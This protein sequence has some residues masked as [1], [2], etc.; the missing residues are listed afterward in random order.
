[1]FSPEGDIDVLISKAKQLDAGNGVGAI[2]ATIE[3]GNGVSGV[4]RFSDEVLIAIAGEDG[5]VSSKP[6]ADEIVASTT[7]G[8]VITGT[9]LKVVVAA[10]TIDGVVATQ[11]ADDIGQGTTDQDV[12]R[13]VGVDTGD[14]EEGICFGRE[15]KP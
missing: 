7:R 8:D 10:E 11:G 3:M 14:I 9:E 6:T 5:D 1:M 2:G 4:G 12:I 13:V 15:V